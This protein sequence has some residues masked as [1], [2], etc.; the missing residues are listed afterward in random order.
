MRGSVQI[1]L[2]SSHR[3]SIANGMKL[4]LREVRTFGPMGPAHQSAKHFLN[5]GSHI[6]SVVYP[7]VIGTHPNQAQ[8]LYSLLK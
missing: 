6:S 1:I 2:S 3:V 8:R 7:A 5:D 4:R